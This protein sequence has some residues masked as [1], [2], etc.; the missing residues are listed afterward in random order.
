[1]HLSH[2]LVCPTGAGLSLVQGL[3]LPDRRLRLGRVYQQEAARIAVFQWLPAQSKA[4][5]LEEKSQKF[6]IPDC[7]LHP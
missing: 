3:A 7:I 2:T 5:Q 6:F 1:M 4:V